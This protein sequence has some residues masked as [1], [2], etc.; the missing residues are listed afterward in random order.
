[1]KEIHLLGILLLIVILVLCFTKIFQEGFKTDQQIH[2]EYNS[3][4]QK[5]YSNVGAA[6]SAA[7]NQAALGS[8]TSQL[9]GSIQDTMDSSN[10][11]IQKRDNPYPVE[12]GVSGMSLVIKQCEATKT[13]DCNLFDTADFSSNCGLC[14]D[15]GTNSEGTPQTGGLVLTT[16]DKKYAKDQQKGNFLPPYV[17]TVGSCPEGKFVATKAECLRLQKELTCQKGGTLNTPA[18]CSQCYN[19]GVYHI[20][21]SSSQDGLIT[22]S[23]ILMVIGSGTLTWSESGSAANSNLSLELTS[24]PQSIVLSGPEYTQIQLTVI[25]HPV[26]KLYQSSKTYRVN[27]LIRYSVNN[28]ENV[29]QM[30]E[31]AGGPGY[32][33]DRVGDQLWSSRGTWATYPYKTA[34]PVFIAGF[35]QSPDGDGFQPMDLYRLILTDSMTGRKPRTMDQITVGDVDVTRMGAGYGKTS[36]NLT[37]FSPFSFVDTLSQE[38][39]LCPSSPFVTQAQSSALLNSDPCYAKGHNT[40][41][42]YSLECLQQTFQNNGCGLS[43]G[44]LEKSGFPTTNAKAAALMV[45]AYGTSLKVNEIADKIYSAAVATA[46]GVDSTGKRMTIADWSA[47][48]MF[49]TGVA[50]NSPCDAV[51]EDGKLTDDCI[52]YLWDNQGENKIPKATYSL[53]SL[54]R[55]LFSA[56]P[57]N[58]FCTRSGTYAPKNSNNQINPTN[59]AYWKNQGDGSVAAVKTAMSELHLA[60]NTSLTNEDVKAPSIQQ[61]YGITPNARPTYATSFQVDQSVQGIPPVLAS[62]NPLPGVSGLVAW[63]DGADPF[64]SDGTIL[65]NGTNVQTWVN[66]FGRQ[67]NAVSRGTSNPLVMNS[68]NGLPGVTISPGNYFKSLIPPG[69]FL[70]ALNVFVV[71]KSTGSNSE[72]GQL[73]TRGLST[74]SNMGN[75]LDMEHSP[76][77]AYGVN[78]MYIGGNNATFYQS[79]ANYNFNN[80]TASIF[81]L[82]LNQSSQASSNLTMYDNGS[83]ITVNPSRGGSRTWAPSDTGDSLCIGGRLDGG[84][85][86]G[87]FYEVLIYNTTIS[88]IDRKKVEGYLATK[89]GLQSAL[90]PGHPYKLTPFGSMPTQPAAGS[91][92]SIKSGAGWSL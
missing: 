80:P 13:A 47:A 63:F 5:K 8:D 59:L 70:S 79:G 52:V 88:D 43:A 25:P 3:A 66:K 64:N 34:T 58:R 27:D 77:V 81:N 91:G 71:Y 36:M 78:E 68:L 50:I 60:A 38:A 33:P 67:Y 56:G 15:I 7:N 41:G 84:N 35:L 44:T 49:C 45:D 40:P 92:S 74:A 6:L 87:I 57:T 17:P 86:N 19:D 20:V 2:N 69:T 72:P 11:I 4:Y 51:D 31:G 22:G 48:S 21:D 9:L 54:A 65:R 73:I 42:T 90:L 75:P 28:V 23:G 29:Y 61:C 85:V 32:P 37:A 83:P 55:S 18:G 26:P 62:V 24:M 14:L 82:N 76:S 39:S 1:M 16:K 10:R 46:T 53:T 89:W 12:G 30:Q